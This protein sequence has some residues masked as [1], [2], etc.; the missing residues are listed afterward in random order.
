MLLRQPTLW[1]FLNRC[2]AVVEREP[3]VGRLRHGT[4]V[5]ADADI[6]RSLLTETRRNYREQSAFFRLGPRVV[7]RSTRKRMVQDLLH[8]LGTWRPRPGEVDAEL[9][10]LGAFSGGLRNRVWGAIAVRR[11]LGDVIANDRDPALDRAVDDYVLRSVV[12]DDIEGRLLGRYRVV[13]QVRTTIAP[14]LAA[15]ARDLRQDG[16]RDLVDVLAPHAETL[17]PIELAQLYQ[18][19]VLSVVGFTGVT[20]EWSMIMSGLQGSGPASEAATLQHVN[21]CLRLYPTAWRLVREVDKPHAI[22]GLAVQPDDAILIAINAIHRDRHLWDRPTE[23]L[24]ARWEVATAEQR[25][26]FMPFGHGAEMC[27]AAKFATRAVG[28]YCRSVWSVYDVRVDWSTRRI[29]HA[30][31]LLAPPGG[32]LRLSPRHN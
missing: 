19:L 12:P 5:V 16:P 30:L 24:P 29:P 28:E 23:F 7:E 15:A 27:P 10:R 17:T 1:P 13:D 6:A 3:K 14:V 32:G 9:A 31:T 20:V 21:E 25:A 18:R 11:Y 26:T 8:V 22:A 4:V 2:E